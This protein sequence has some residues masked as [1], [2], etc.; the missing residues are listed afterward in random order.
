LR[1]T[2]LAVLVE[3]ARLHEVRQE[4]PR[5]IEA[6]LQVLGVEPAHEEAHAGLMRLYA[7]AGQRHQALRQYQQ[8]CLA[9]RRELDAE[10]DGTSQGLYQAILAGQFPSQPRAAQGAPAPV[11][12]SP[13]A[14]TVEAR[15]RHNLPAALTRFV[16]RE[17]E[18]RVLQRLLS[19]QPSDPRLVTLTG[20]G[21]CGKTRLAL[22]VASSLVSSY[23]DGVWLVEL[24]PLADPA[25]VPQAIASTL[26]LPDEANRPPTEAL[27]HH[28]QRRQLLLIVDNCEHLI[29]ACAEAA[30]RLL[31]AC[32][33]VQILATSRQ[34]LGLTGETAWPVPPLS[35]PD[36]DHLPPLDDLS[37]YEAIQLFVERARA[38]QPRF[39]L[40]RDKAPSVARICQHLDGLPLAIE[41][42]AARLRV[43]PAEQIA[44]RLGDRFQLLTGGGRTA[45]PRQQTLRAT[46]EWS[47]DLLTPAE[48]ILFN[49]LSIFAGGWT[50]E[51]AEAICGDDAADADRA[52]GAPTPV[53]RRTSA[54]LDLLSGLVDKS[55]VVVEAET[56]GGARYRLLETLRQYAEERLVASGETDGM[57]ARHAIYYLALARRAEPALTGA[58][59]VRWLD[60]LEREHDNIR[61]ALEWSRAEPQRLEHGLQLAAAT[62]R[63]WWLRGHLT[64]GRSRLEALLA[65]ASPSIRP[66]VR[67]RALHALGVLCFR[68]GAYAVA[69][70][71]LEQC[72]ALAAESSDQPGVAA[73]LRQL[74]RMA[75]DR[76]E[77]AVARAYLEQ[78]LAIERELGGA[79]GRGWSLGYLGLLTH[80]EGNN[81]AALPLLE[82][83]LSLLRDLGDRLA[84]PVLLYYLGRVAREQRDYAL[85]RKHWA[86]S[87]A[88][89][90]A[91]RY[92]WPVPYLLEAFADLAIGQG[93]AG[94]GVALAGAAAA[95]HETIGAPLPPV[96]Q[97]DFL[98]RL[99]RA[100]EVL[101]E[102]AYASAWSAGREMPLE[103]AIQDALTQEH[104]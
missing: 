58:E 77:F 83:S 2:Y 98:R 32:P 89:C 62:W 22:E 86:E 79:Y 47:Y 57:R 100:H 46:V 43:L 76:G 5:A 53:G 49:R 69:R 63:F 27:I 20:V 30:D 95:L 19:G 67:V 78:S 23:R 101:D 31:R 104:G 50:L 91:Q 102:Q 80:F 38:S 24:A 41:L 37:R 14:E 16:G 92:L 45:S 35:L 61:A 82:D 48:Q 75:I 33:H 55:L 6:L 34:P 99:E 54:I 85:A 12:E 4:W 18:R 96:W 40:T 60:H 1:R 68:Q 17:A 88:L 73:A 66:D 3:L 36:P 44:A 29:E 74:G 9:L 90:S 25:L 64:E 72:L 42:A 84:A 39:A 51:A 52:D 28:L 87:L 7:L 21:G 11:D 56:E 70:A 71:H 8:L 15:A 59:Q 103:Q 97:A 10:P 94:R 65:E 81:T 13:S 93:Q 26:S